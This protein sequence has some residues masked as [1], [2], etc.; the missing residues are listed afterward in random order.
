M[1]RIKL[2]ITI[3]SIVLFFLS[4]AVNVAAS[5]KLDSSLCF[6]NNSSLS[7]PDS[8]TDTTQIMGGVWNNH[9]TRISLAGF[10]MGVPLGAAGSALGACYSCYSGKCS[11]LSFESCIASVAVGSALFAVPVM[12]SLIA[13]AIVANRN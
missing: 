3:S 8:I 11:P 12:T 4:Q 7:T 6:N 9:C 1:Q 10:F 2:V 5:A 13:A